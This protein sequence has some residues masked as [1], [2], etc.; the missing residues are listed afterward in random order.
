MT[1]PEP[2]RRFDVDKVAWVRIV[3][4]ALE[5]VDTGKPYLINHGGKRERKQNG[6]WETDVE[7]LVREV[8][9]ETGVTLDPSTAAHLFTIEGTT[10][11]G[12]SIREAY[13]LAQG[14]KE[15]VSREATIRGFVLLKS[16]AIGKSQTTPVGEAALA[17]LKAIDFID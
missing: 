4:R 9:E 10:V 13:Y 7:V 3:A 5:M 14:D 1:Q 15:P 16:D 17:R 11:D 2:E 6:A 12:R 8:K